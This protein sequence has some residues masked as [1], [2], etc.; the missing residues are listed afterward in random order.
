MDAKIVSA[1]HA[2]NWEEQKL[3]LEVYAKDE[4]GY[5]CTTKRTKDNET[6][7]CLRAKQIVLHDGHSTQTQFYHLL[8]EI[9]HVKQQKSLAYYKAKFTSVFDVFSKTS[10]T[11]KVK[12]IEEEIDAWNIGLKLVEDMGLHIDYR[13]YEICRA[14]RLGSYLRWAVRSKEKK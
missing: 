4:L 12:I 3:A 14:R 8:H 13:K 2:V 6:W 11:Y 10:L 9:G 5:S 7:V 1:D